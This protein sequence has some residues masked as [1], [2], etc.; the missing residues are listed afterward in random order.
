MAT[1]SIR[2]LHPQ[3]HESVTR[4]RL[5]DSCDADV[6]HSGLTL[7]EG[8]SA[9]DYGCHWQTSELERTKIGPCK[10]QHDEALVSLLPRGMMWTQAALLDDRRHL[11]ASGTTP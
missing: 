9:L 1:T 10:L 7:S 5:D 6:K 3:S 4:S 8:D 2:L 11:D